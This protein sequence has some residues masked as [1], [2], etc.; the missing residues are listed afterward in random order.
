MLKRLVVM[1]TLLMAT[2]GSAIAQGYPGK[3]VKV[4]VPYAAGGATDMIVRL[5]CQILQA[6]LGQS[7]VVENRPGGGG[8]IGIEQVARSQPDGHTL[9]GVSTGPATISPLLF[10]ERNFDPIASL[11]PVILF[12][13]TPGVLVVRPEGGPSSVEALV[14]DSV[15]RPGAL[16][17]ASAGNGSLQQMMGEVFQARNQLRWT[18]IPF[19]GTAPALNEVMAGRAD[20]MFDVVAS[21]SALISAGKLRPL[22][23]T[24]ARRATRLPEVPTLEELG[25]KGFDFSGW[26]A[27]IAPKGTPPAVL[28][29]LNE[30]LNAALIRT[31]T[32]DR[33]AQM[34]AE[35]LGGGPDVLAEQMKREIAEWNKTLQRVSIKVD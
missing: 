11:E 9:L 2:L 4:V 31:E 32:R 18:H 30:V 29:R 10:K 13:R 16:N 34:G 6:E 7:F 28:R 8:L 21:T 17:M 26:H 23:V 15:A 24:T 1:A 20:V 3:P 25:Y 33:L 19:N 12:A 14:R 22:A 27:L 5:M 35:P